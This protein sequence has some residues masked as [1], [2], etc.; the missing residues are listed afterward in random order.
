MKDN[1][2]HRQ[3][4]IHNTDNAKSRAQFKHMHISNLSPSTNNRQRIIIA[5]NWLANLQIK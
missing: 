2:I 3:N 4:F 5:K 1:F